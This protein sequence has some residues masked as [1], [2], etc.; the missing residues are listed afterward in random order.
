MRNNQV[1]P[2]GEQHIVVVVAPPRGLLQKYASPQAEPRKQILSAQRRSPGPLGVVDVARRCARPGC[3]T[4]PRRKKGH[5]IAQT[6]ARSK[7][8]CSCMAEPRRRLFF[9]FRKKSTQESKK[10]RKEKKKGDGLADAREP[11][12]SWVL[13]IRATHVHTLTVYD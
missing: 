5:E 4:E 6:R 9:L 11:G 8:L 13:C 2:C 12:R 10:K 3:V 1:W 7:A